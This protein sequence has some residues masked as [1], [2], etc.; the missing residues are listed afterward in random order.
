MTVESKITMTTQT[1]RLTDVVTILGPKFAERAATHDRDDSFVHENYDGL[2][3]HKVFSVGLPKEYGGGGASFSQICDFLRGIAGY[4]SSTGLALAMHQHSLQ[5]LLWRHRKDPSPKI[6]GVLRKFAAEELVALT[7][8]ASDWLEPT[9]EAMKVDGGYRVTGRKIF[10][11]GSPRAAMIFTSAKF[12]QPDGT[13]VAMHFALPLSTEGVGMEETWVAHGMRGTGSNDIVLENV[14]V[15]DEAISVTRPYG[16]WHAALAV[17]VS[18]SMPMVM[19]AYLGVAERAAALALEKARGKSSPETIVIAGEMQ[20]HLE[21]AR[22]AT[23]ALVANAN[24]GAFE[25]TV[26]HVDR[27]LVHKA[28]ATDGVIATVESAVELVGGAAFFRRSPLE[29]LLRDVRAAHFHPLQD[30]RQIVFTGRVALGLEP[31][32]K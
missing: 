4:C 15:A 5:Q 29:R 19:S 25:P 18:C 16:E 22:L 12:A 32:A 23:A 1:A 11:S 17:A 7:S 20:N 8:G 30:K 21:K 3:A 14:F 2:K 28:M 6:E 31:V 26:D 10:A 27:L 9:A 24:E 13:L